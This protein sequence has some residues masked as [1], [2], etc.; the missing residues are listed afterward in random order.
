[1]KNVYRVLAYLIA[2]MV[3]FQAAAIAFGVFTLANQ[4]DKGAVIT[5]DSQTNL[6][7]NLH[8]IGGTMVIPILVLLLLI[9]SFFT[10]VP[11]AVKW[12]ALV[13]ALVAVQITLAFLAFSVPVLGALH[14]MNALAILA[15]SAYAGRRVSR[16]APHDV[17]GAQT[18]AE[19]AETRSRARL[20][21]RRRSSV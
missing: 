15:A 20:L 8:G 5:S 12:A 2:A 4:V 14:G 6:G 18:P 3:F 1:M 13:F 7:Q 17:S 19:R 10:R 16:T 11:G 21:G 9:T